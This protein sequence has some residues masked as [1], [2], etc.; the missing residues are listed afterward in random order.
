MIVVAKPGAPWTISAYASADLLW[1]RPID[2]R[3]LDESRSR[4]GRAERCALTKSGACLPLAAMA[5]PCSHDISIMNGQDQQVAERDQVF[6][7]V[8]GRGIE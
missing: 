5:F 3:S 4:L 2:R 1:S 6:A 8:L 7:Q